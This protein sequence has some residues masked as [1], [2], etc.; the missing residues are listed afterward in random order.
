MPKLSV[1]ELKAMLKA[2]ENEPDESIHVAEDMIRSRTNSDDTKDGDSRSTNSMSAAH[3]R[4]TEAFITKNLSKLYKDAIASTSDGKLRHKE[5]RDLV[6]ELAGFDPDHGQMLHIMDELDE[7]GDGDISLEEWISFGIKHTD[8][9]K[10]EFHFD[11][12]SDHPVDDR[13]YYEKTVQYWNSIDWDENYWAAKDYMLWFLEQCKLSV[14]FDDLMMFM[15]LFVLF[16][17]NIKLISSEKSADNTFEVCNTIG[18]FFFVAEFLAQSWSKTEVETWRPFVA[19]GYLLSFYWWL[20]ILSILSMF[21]D[22][23][24][25]SEG[26]GMGDISNAVQGNN[27][28]T[29]AGRIVRLVRLVRLVKLYKMYKDKKKKLDQEKEMMELVRVG[30]MSYDDI[31]RQQALYQD[32]QSK[33]GAKLDNSITQ[34]VILLV[35]TMVII[36]PLCTYSE[37]NYSAYTAMDTLYNTLA[38]NDIDATL[39]NAVVEDVVKRYDSRNA[40]SLIFLEIEPSGSYPDN[41]IVNDVALIN[42]LRA[43]AVIDITYGEK[44]SNVFLHAKFDNRELVE[45]SAKLGI[46]L[47]VFIGFMLVLGTTLFNNDAQVTVLQPIEHMMN[48]LDAVVKD[49]LSPLYFDHTDPCGPGEYETRL[50]E[51]TI[52]KITGLLRVGFG[53]AGAGI[54]SANLSFDSGNKINPLLPGVRVYV[55][56]GFC[57]IHHFEEVLVKLTD[58]VLTFVNSIAEIVHENVAHWGGQCNKNL[59]NAFVILW[60]IDDEKKL[61][62]VLNSSKFSKK[63]NPVHAAGGESATSKAIKEAAKRQSKVI[64]LR[65]VPGINILADQALIGYLKI[66]AEINRSKAILKYRNEPRLTHNGTEPFKVSMGFGLHAGWA[67]EGA[68]GSLYKVDATYLSPHVNMAARLETSSRQYGVPLLASHFVHELLSPEVKAKCRKVDVVTVKGSEVPVGVYT[69]D[70]L[71]DQVFKAKPL[72]PAKKGGKKQSAATQVKTDE[73]D[74]DAVIHSALATVAKVGSATSAKYNYQ[75]VAPL[76]IDFAD[77]FLAGDMNMS[78]N[79]SSSAKNQSHASMKARADEEDATEGFF[80]T[81]TSDTVEVFDMD[82]DMLMLRAHVANNDEFNL[83]FSEGIKVYL[84][85]DWTTARKFLEKANK[86]MARAAPQLG[87]DGPCLTLLEYMGERNWKAPSDWG[88][89]RPL[90]AK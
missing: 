5:I 14:S 57:D 45:E 89:F 80:L 38:D 18:L 28:I 32:R 68:V 27:N 67:I 44:N 50:L 4:K 90:T 31:M 77:G 70:C 81:N 60:R 19:Q 42:Q 22:I 29:R 82:D 20:D 69:Y 23:S 53:E 49:P 24:W 46:G 76:D 73:E 7:D 48:M 17:D 71:E 78:P 36:L 84:E 16:G 64:D 1:A 37:S 35:L 33:L 21:P 66:I 8:H 54:I 61:H 39:R 3:R 15:T 85:G 75:S 10:H 51:S 9:E 56:V 26:L 40:L 74:V 41:V 12:V 86:L 87:G 63:D 13:T 59:G 58:D 62:E 30:E 83:V 88:G 6:K 52:E 55:I 11:E 25:I 72:V 65:R 79:S 2:A 34:R 43:S 47:T